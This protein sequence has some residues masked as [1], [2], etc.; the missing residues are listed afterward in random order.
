MI[1]GR[2]VGT[3]PIRPLPL[4]KSLHRHGAQTAATVA[5]AV[6]RIYGVEQ[7]NALT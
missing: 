4:T 5:N 7:G 3:A 1:S 2:P 6:H